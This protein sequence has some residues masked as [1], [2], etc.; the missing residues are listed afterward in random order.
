MVPWIFGRE[1]KMSF[2]RRLEKR[3]LRE[4]SRMCLNFKMHVIWKLVL[5]LMSIGNQEEE[6][7]GQSKK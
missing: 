3:S 2:G 5:A 7:N 1:E 4:E 6:Q